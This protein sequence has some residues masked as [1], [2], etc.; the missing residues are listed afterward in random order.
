MGKGM[1]ERN[2]R[3]KETRRGELKDKKGPGESENPEPEE[4]GLGKGVGC[5]ARRGVLG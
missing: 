4:I 1:G 2:T 3:S 5:V